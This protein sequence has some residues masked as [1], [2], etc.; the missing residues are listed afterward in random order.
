MQLYYLT[1]MIVLFLVGWWCK[2]ATEKYRAVKSKRYKCVNCGF[3]D[4][5]DV[6]FEKTCVY[7]DSVVK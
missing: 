2:T 3:L 6:T 1:F 4:W 7:C 5:E